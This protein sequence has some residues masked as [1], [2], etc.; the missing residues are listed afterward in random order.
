MNDTTTISRR[1]VL[2]ATSTA[3]TVGAVQTASA[4]VDPELTDRSGMVD[5]IVR[6]TAGQYEEIDEDTP[7]EDV[8]KALKEHAAATQAEVVDYAERT[9][10]IDVERRFWVANALKV[11][12]D[13]TTASLMDLAAIDGVERVHRAVTGSQ[14]R[15][16]EFEDATA[17]T[18]TAQTEE[19]SY[20]LEMMNVPALWERF[21]TRGDGARVA[22]IDS[23]V[24][25]SHPD[26]DLAEWAEFDADGQ[27]VD[28][29]PHDPYG[30]GTGMSS[31]ATGGDA[32]GTQIGAAPEADLLFAKQAKEGWVASTLAALEWA[33]E[34]RADAVSMSF[35]LG[36]LVTEAI[37]PIGNAIAAGA[38][39]VVPTLGPG[40]YLSPNSIYDALNTGT[41]D[42]E[43]RAYQNGNGGEIRTD[44]YWR[45]QAVPDDWPD[46]Y[47]LPTVTAPGV[48]NLQAL[49]DNDR[50]DGGHAEQTG[51][52]N[53]APYVSGVIALLRSLDGSLTPA[54]IEQ[55]LLETAEQ[56]GGPHEREVPN[57]EFGHGVVNAVGAA[58][59]LLGRSA[60]VSGTVTSPDGTPI[61]GATVSAMTGDSTETDSDGQYALSVLE[62]EA[63]IT[64][65]AVGYEPVTRRVSPGDG[66]DIPF[67]AERRP[68]IQR[69]RAEPTHLSPGES[70][71][72][73]LEVRH[74]EFATVFIGDSA[75]PIDETAVSVRLNGEPVE[76]G[77]P[78]NVEGETTLQIA[79]DIDEGTRGILRL[80]VGL[81]DEERNTF[82][83]V[84]PIHVHERPLRV[85]AGESIQNA[86]DAAAPETVLLLAGERWE[87]PIE[88]YDSPLPESRF[89]IPVYRD[90]RDHEA[91]LIVDKPVTLR[92]ADDAEPTLVATGESDSPTFG[93]EVLDHFALL[94]DVE[95]VAEGATAAVGVLDGDGV[96]IRNV[97]LSGATNGVSARVTKSLVVSGSDI[98]AIDTGVELRDY[99]VNALVEDNTIGDAD[100]GV[101]L[102]GRFGEQ[103]FDVDATVAGNTYEGVG[104]EVARE[105]TATILDTDGQPIAGGEQPPSESSLDLLLYVATATAIGALFYPYGKRKL[106]VK[107]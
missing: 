45:D 75:V 33:V 95:V 35:D 34:N 62:G 27:R 43:R 73:E 99:S 78:T 100:R 15:T 70:V 68:D 96:R 84:D 86:I 104:T 10:G 50:F 76:L 97:T 72:I 77:E 52:S 90:S 66:R 56:P 81:A 40:F 49:P 22:V 2:A 89:E 12:V 44:R 6:L 25:T 51:P 11:T 92:A 69:A 85:E 107:R 83:N 54:E 17:G 46:R 41:V 5:G 58:S 53:T 57:G 93:V 32:S 103:L 42:R 106:R 24:D 101:F 9:P 13:T 91:G 28:S 29:D 48:D 7:R 87:I 38:V 23:G 71:S 18:L 60:D 88:P 30:H 67:E 64:V 4:S 94:R 14:R 21:D 79:V 102:S 61:G 98:S 55:A 26:I 37:E 36:P 16:E 105:G 82:L 65:S 63:T 74:A 8:L 47:V 31:L 19:V 80:G 3:A 59:E 39:V 20:G 1:G